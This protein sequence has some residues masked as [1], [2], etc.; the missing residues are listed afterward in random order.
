VQSRFFLLKIKVTLYIIQTQKETKILPK[1]K[2]S[3]FLNNNNKMSKNKQLGS[4]LTQKD[5]ENLFEVICVELS[6][7]NVISSNGLNVAD[8]D[9][10]LNQPLQLKKNGTCLV[11]DAFLSFYNG[12]PVSSGNI[13][14]ETDYDFTM[15]F[16]LIWVNCVDDL[17]TS[18]AP[19]AYQIPLAY[20]S[21]LTD[22]NG[23]LILASVNISIKAGSYTPG[24]LVQEF[25]RQTSSVQYLENAVNGLIKNPP[26]SNTVAGNALDFALIRQFT[27]PSVFFNLYTQGISQNPDP[28][29]GYQIIAVKDTSKVY[30]IPSNQTI[31]YGSNGFLLDYDEN[32]QKFNI[33]SNFM[34]L[35]NDDNQAFSV[36]RMNDPNNAG[37][38]IFIDRTAECLVQNWGYTKSEWQSSFWY[39]LGFE[40]SDLMKTNRSDPNMFARTFAN[41]D[42]LDVDQTTNSAMCYPTLKGLSLNQSV[43]NMAADGSNVYSV[44]TYDGSTLPIYASKAANLIPLPYV[45]AKL[46][47]Q[48]VGGY[49]N[50]EALYSFVQP[51]SLLDISSSGITSFSILN[52]IMYMFPSEMN[53]GSIHVTLQDPRDDKPLTWLSKQMISSLFLR[54]QQ[55]HH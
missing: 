13:I 6:N 14:I 21:I 10:H 26:V 15:Q 44:S 48:V 11:S 25:N 4:D 51:V 2:R 36:L 45:R 50:D 33:S 30:G 18:G 37:G 38:R 40:S 46:D 43:I 42:L 22:V 17:A 47:L 29:F 49:R 27:A 3:Y 12:S 5:S 28:D 8:F 16:A 7:K 35:I 54:I 34:P 39:R 32:L 53:I 20:Q 41:I 9:V 31:I 19:E 52:P 1:K 23:Q 55:P 24:A